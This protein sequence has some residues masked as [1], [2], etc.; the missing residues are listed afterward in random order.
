MSRFQLIIAALA[1]VG[2][3]SGTVWAQSAE[4]KACYAKVTGGGD[5]LRAGMVKC[6]KAELA[7]Q[8]RRLNAAYKSVMAN[9]SRLG[10]VNA[11]PDKDGLRKKL[12]GA[13]RAWIGF[14]DADCAW[15]A[16]L[17]ARGPEAELAH[18]TCMVRVTRA[19]A[20][21]LAGLAKR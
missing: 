8:D 2:L 1:W 14:R 12:R 9:P 16:D 21:F 20:N 10:G 15:A 3:G 5:A 11:N 7:R 4:Q 17:H 19:R 18:A 13:Q 6:E